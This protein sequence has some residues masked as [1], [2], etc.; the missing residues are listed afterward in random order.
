[1]KRRAVCVKAVPRE[2]LPIYF[3]IARAGPGQ[4]RCALLGFWEKN[5]TDSF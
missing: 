2:S 4:S 3:V 1:M 5:G